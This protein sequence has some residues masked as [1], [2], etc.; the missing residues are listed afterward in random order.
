MMR[1]FSFDLKDLT[2]YPILTT[3][4]LC[5]T[6][7]LYYPRQWLMIPS[8][9]SKMLKRVFK[10]SLLIFKNRCYL[11]VS[12][13]T[14]SQLEENLDNNL[15]CQWYFPSSYQLSDW[16][17]L[18][19]KSLIIAVMLLDMK[20]HMISQLNWISST[21]SLILTLDLSCHW[22]EKVW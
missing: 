1:C 11:T 2:R 3:R 16:I 8:V 7:F 17:G 9:F 12:W 18:H 20:L 5:T 19:F 10:F 14:F 15:S 21:I 6:R 4:P 13:K 22:Q